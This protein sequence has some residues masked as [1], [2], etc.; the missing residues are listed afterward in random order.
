MAEGLEELNRGRRAE[1]DRAYEEAKEL[2]GEE[3][4][5]VVSGKWHEGVIG[6]V[7]GK[8]VEEF[9]RPAFVLTEA[10]GGLLKGSAR[11]FGGFDLAAALEA[12]RGL[13]VKGGGHRQAAGLTMEKQNLYKFIEVIC[14]FYRKLGLENQEA[15]LLAKPDLVV[16]EV[17][18]LTAEFYRETRLLEPYGEGNPEPVFGLE[19]VIVAE[20]R[21]MG[22]GERHLAVTVVGRDG[23]RLRLVAWDAPA[24]WRYEPGTRV[25]VVF[26]L[27]AD[28]WRGVERVEGRLVRITESVA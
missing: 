3:P 22:A 12:V 24:E 11:S 25:D 18:E 19:G 26:R 6:I 9:G 17:G 7:A 28:E 4:V 10:K 8:L 21:R 5:I 23:A 16:E 2:V 1:Q 15:Y 13:L 20:M 27:T 14:T